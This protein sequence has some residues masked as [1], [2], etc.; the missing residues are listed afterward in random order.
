M[1]QD[2]SFKVKLGPFT[3]SY[4]EKEDD[5]LKKNLGECNFEKLEIE[6]RKDLI[7][8]IKI[9]TIF[10]EIIHAAFASSG[11]IP[12]NEE[13]ITDTLACQLL[14]FLR[15]NPDF[16]D[17]LKSKSKPISGFSIN[18]IHFGKDIK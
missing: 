7:N 6:V 12:K 17:Y 18:L 9:S 14:F 13:I 3:W 11:V 8:D 2:N 5:L 15:N 4:C 16:L 1:N 10:H